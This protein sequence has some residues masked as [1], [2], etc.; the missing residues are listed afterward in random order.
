MEHLDQHLGYELRVQVVQLKEVYRS[1]EDFHGGPGYYPAEQIIAKHNHGVT[2]AN[3]PH[4]V[5]KV[6]TGNIIGI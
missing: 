3:L 5:E 1:K 4:V 6:A 2:E